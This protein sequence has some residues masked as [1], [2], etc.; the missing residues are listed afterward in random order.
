L[1]IRVSHGR[2]FAYGTN[3]L[4]DLDHAVI[5]DVE[6]SRAIRRAEVGSARTIIDRTQDRF[7]LWPAKLAADSAYGSAETSPGWSMSTGSSRIPRSSTNPSAATA[8]SAAPTSPMTARAI[9]TH[10]RREG[11]ATTP[12]RLSN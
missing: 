12:E 10:A 8:P 7:G 1:S 2:F 6:A 5:V 9:S 11:V 4:I 3:Y